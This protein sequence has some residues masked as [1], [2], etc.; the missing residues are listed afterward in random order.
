MPFSFTSFSTLLMIVLVSQHCQSSESAFQRIV[1]S[2]MLFKICLLTNPYGNLNILGYLPIVL[3]T[4]ACVFSISFNPCSSDNFL[5][6]GCEYEWFP[7]SL[8]WS[9]MYFNSSAY[10]STLQPNTKKVAFMFNSSNKLTIFLLLK[11]GPSSKELLF[12]SQCY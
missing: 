2:L 3:K 11:L 1:G 5:K 10:F 7:I 8:P 4:I 12:C 6:S 9:F